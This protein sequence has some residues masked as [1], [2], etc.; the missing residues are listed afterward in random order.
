MW[1]I[2]MRMG[3]LVVLVMMMAGVILNLDVEL[4][5]TQV[6]SN[7]SGRSNTISV[8]IQLP[9]L[10]TQII[11]IHSEIQQRANRHVA[12]DARE[13]IEVERLHRPKILPRREMVRFRLMQLHVHA[14]IKQTLQSTIRS[15]WNIEPPDIVL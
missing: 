14:C 6:G 5:C 7:D 10:C 8:Q 2:A 15:L 12:A 13:A 3:V 11:E 4:H 9:Q 1:G